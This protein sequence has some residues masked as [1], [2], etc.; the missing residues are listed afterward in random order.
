MTC[1]STASIWLVL[2][3]SGG[4]ADS[5]DKL[6]HE[7]GQVPY[8]SLSVAK[9]TFKNTTGQVARIRNMWSSCR[10]ATPS[11]ANFEAQ[12]GENLV[13]EVKYDAST[14][15]GAR[16]MTIYVSFESPVVETVG[17]RVNGFSRHD[18]VCNPGLVDFGVLS[19]GS[20]VDARST[21]I[22]Y[23][24][25]MDWKITEVVQPKWFEATLK[26]LYRDSGRAGYEATVKLKPGAPD[27]LVTE[28]IVFKT[29]D[30]TSPTVQV[31]ATVSVQAALQASPS[32]LELG[33]M[34]QGEKVTKRV[35]LKGSRPFSVV[36]VGGSTDGVNVMSTQ[37]PKS[38]HI[39]DVEFSAKLEGK[40]DQY[41]R[42]RTDLKEEQPIPVRI[43]ADV[44]K[45][46]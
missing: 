1:F 4:L 12:P 25:A 6:S 11:A 26:E 41:I 13:V 43:L 15:T 17:L 20:G 34:Q 28:A 42:F 7:F 46:P 27:G 33:T 39:V 32:S 22:E 8:G 40:V 36:S 10:C 31:Q 14:F 18:V 24:G 5:F 45:H 44:K 37:G 35:L 3:L 38:V 16:S 2:S 30:S 19:K 29:N 9:F 21:K 23:A